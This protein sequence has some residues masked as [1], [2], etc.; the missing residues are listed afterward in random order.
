MIRASTVVRNASRTEFRFRGRE[1][2]WKPEQFSLLAF[3]QVDHLA[4]EHQTDR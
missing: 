4:A 1:F 3:N 2:A